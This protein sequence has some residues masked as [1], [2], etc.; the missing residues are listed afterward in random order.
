M[1][2]KNTSSNDFRI[3]FSVVVPPK[4]INSYFDGLANV[5][6]AKK[7][8][9]I[10][11]LVQGLGTWLFAYM[12]TPL[13]T[14]NYPQHP[15]A[16]SSKNNGAPTTNHS[17]KD[18]TREWCP[19]CPFNPPR[20]TVVK[21]P[22]TIFPS[23]S[24]TKEPFVDDI[25]A[26]LKQLGLPSSFCDSLWE[27]FKSGCVT[28]DSCKPKEDEKKSTPELIIEGLMRA[29]LDQNPIPKGVPADSVSLE[30]TTKEKLEHV[31]RCD[32]T[33]A[34]THTKN[35]EGEKKVKNTSPVKE[36][37]PAMKNPFQNPEVKKQ[38]CS[39][40]QEEIQK[41]SEEYMEKLGTFINI[42]GLDKECRDLTLE[43]VK[44][45]MDGLVKSV[46]QHMDF[47]QDNTEVTKT[48]DLETSK[49]GINES[50]R[51]ENPDSTKKN[52]NLVNLIEEAQK[53]ASNT[54]GLNQIKINDFLPLL[55]NTMGSC[56]GEPTPKDSNVSESVLQKILKEE[57]EIYEKNGEEEDTGPVTDFVSKAFQE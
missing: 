30:N 35:T 52:T 22:V 44:Q 3:D 27:E 53:F 10:E 34:N 45:N 25:T 48:I 26:I 38:E 9:W 23:K 13:P 17:K 50:E 5:E 20:N 54:E 37:A 47:N 36:E 8:K 29:Y 49:Q 4:V 1:S 24:S 7:E 14:Y 28:Q 18:H 56:M 6:E 11:P 33:C 43:F 51:M 55:F 46:H 57:H 2:N 31:V 41:R 39:L 42:F 40:S 21:D 15:L 32:N 12:S 19:D 16:H